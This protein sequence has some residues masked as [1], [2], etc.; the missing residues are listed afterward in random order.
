MDG[1]R[2]FY[3][4]NEPT[5]KE[6]IGY[7]AYCKDEIFDGDEHV[8]EADLM[9]HKSCFLLENTGKEPGIND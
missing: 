4:D 9:F 7:C 8:L 1:E 3:G 5:H 2:D 6:C